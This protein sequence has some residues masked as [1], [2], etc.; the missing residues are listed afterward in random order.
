ESCE[1][2]YQEKDLEEGSCPFHPGKPLSTIRE[3]NYFFALSRYAKPLL[4][5]IRAHPEF[6]MPETRRH[7]IV[8]LIEQGLN[9]ISVSRAGGRWGIPLPVDESHVVYVWFDALINYITA[10]GYGW[11]EARFQRWWP[12]ELHVIGKDITRF[13][14]VIWPAMLLSAGIELPRT[15][16]GHGFVYHRGERISKTL[17]NVINPLDIVDRFGPDPLR[18]FL[19]REGSFGKDSDFTWENFINR[20]NHDLG[21]DLGNLLQRTL[22][23]IRRYQGGTIRRPDR[24]SALRGEPFAELEAAVEGVLSRIR[25]ALDPTQKDIDFPVALQEIWKLVALGNAYLDRMKPWSLQ[26]GGEGDAVAAVLHTVAD[27]LRIVAGLLDP[28]LPHTA[29]AIRR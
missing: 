20:Y 14:C 11:D 3:E 29:V 4:D 22:G 9:D 10:V 28:F 17:G 8:A 7:E 2:F 21:N 19:M 27:L 25:E 6:I 16:F 24:L 26:K 15:I 1:A 5:H 23:M 18:Y 13:H 12:A